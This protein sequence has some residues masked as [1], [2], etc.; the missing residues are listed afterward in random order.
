MLFWRK[1][2]KPAAIVLTVAWI[3]RT[4]WDITGAQTVAVIWSLL[5]PALS[6]VIWWRPEDA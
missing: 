2:A 3:F 4:V 1:L 6:I 5:L